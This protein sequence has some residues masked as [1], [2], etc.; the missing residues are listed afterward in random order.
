[1]DKTIYTREYAALLRLLR[2]KRVKSGV[3]QVDLAEGL[4]IHQSS[5]SKLERGERRIDVIQLRNI[6]ELIGGSLPEF[7]TELE[8]AISSS[9]ASRKSSRRK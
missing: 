7:V 5:Y 3:N 4:G 6:V 2:S 9:K 8:K 1:M